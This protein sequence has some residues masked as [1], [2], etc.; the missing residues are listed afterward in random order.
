MINHI[1]KGIHISGSKVLQQQDRIRELGI[2]AIVRVDSLDRANAQWEKSFALLDMPFNDGFAVPPIVFSKVTQFIHEQVQAEQKILVHCHMGVS[3]SVTMVLAYLIEHEKMSLGQA[4]HV[5]VT[6][7]PIAYP[8]D[9]LI[10][11]LVV[12]YRLP[13]TPEQIKQP[14]F[15]DSLKEKVGG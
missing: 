6:G 3:R 1:Y 11:S 15:L 14:F 8:H 4:Y 13:Y 12:H 9:A 7:R 2:A 10:N 5:V